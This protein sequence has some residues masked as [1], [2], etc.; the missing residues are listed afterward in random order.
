MEE[1]LQPL[2]S[3][4]TALFFEAIKQFRS[5]EFVQTPVAGRMLEEMLKFLKIS[6]NAAVVGCLWH[7]K[8]F[9]EGIQDIWIYACKT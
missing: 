7:F 6:N 2:L 5:Y 9:F 4:Q 8:T 1:K 3:V